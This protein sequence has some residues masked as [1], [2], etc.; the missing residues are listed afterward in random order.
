L[1]TVLSRPALTITLA[2]EPSM[3][4]SF[5]VIESEKVM[6]IW[7]FS[8]LLHPAITI[9]K[10]SPD[11]MYR[12]SMARRGLPSIAAFTTVLK[13]PISVLGPWRRRS[14]RPT[15]PF[16]EK[17]VMRHQLGLASVTS[18]GASGLTT[19]QSSLRSS[20]SSPGISSASCHTPSLPS[21]PIGPIARSILSS[22]PRN[23]DSRKPLQPGSYSEF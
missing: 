21:S 9:R 14:V 22:L 19:T 13:M 10:S 15:I 3:L 17:P 12:E 18:K 7:Q 2:S 4:D 8:P 5:I 6:V 1:A 11:P 20:S 16:S 23:R